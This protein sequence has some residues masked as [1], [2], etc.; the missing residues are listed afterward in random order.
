MLDPIKKTI[1]YDQ[2]AIYYN[3]GIEKLMEKAG[4]GIADFINKKYKK[5]SRIGFFCG[6]G[7]NGG[8]GFVAARYLKRDFKVKVFLIPSEDK[9]NTQESRVN[10]QKFKG[11]KLDSVTPADIK[12]EFDIVVDCLFG[13]GIK[14]KLRKPYPT[15]IKKLNQLKA[16]KITID[17]P[18]P[19]FKPDVYLSMMFKKN[20]NAHV[21]DI[22]YPKKLKNLIGIGEF[23]VL[24]KPKENSHKGNNGR[25]LIIA[26]SKKYHGAPVLAVKTISKI[27]DLVY[28]SSVRENL[29]LLE[30]MKLKSSE[31]IS[32]KFKD[33]KS[34]LANKKI[35]AIL[36][37]P[38]LEVN[39]ENKKLLKDLI[40]KNHK[41]KFIFDAGAFEIFKEK[42][43][44]NNSSDK[45]YSNEKLL[46]KLKNSIFT[47]HKTEF[48]KLFNLEA[49]VKNLKK[50]VKK[51]KFTLVLKGKTDYVAYFEKHEKQNKNNNH[52]VVIK[53]NLTGN[54]GL[55]KGGTGDVL[56]GLTAA[57]ATN[58]PNFLAAS[59]AVFINGLAADQLKE[60]MSYYYNASDL[61]KQIP[62]TMTWAEK[63]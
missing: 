51:Y 58:N 1:L 57:L 15:I 20:K 47:P 10:W 5:G 34:L 56:A 28:F 35:N 55:T 37:G 19:G 3:Y 52:N 45:N 50:I 54:P 8:D 42:N 48:K 12:D 60:K 23:K 6:P 25:L 32:V 14:G 16:E 11:Q 63:F 40:A 43:L 59:A 53:K 26:G 30:K 33:L 7:N 46:K 13:T 27:V 29:K 18:S 24:N 17:L 2:N 39:P 62:K 41:Q 44:L 36:I 31:F 61:V 38:G 9:I 49:N 21:I 22:G 4:Q